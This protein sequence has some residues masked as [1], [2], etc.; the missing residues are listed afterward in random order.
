MLDTHS[1]NLTEAIRSLVRDSRER[2]HPITASAPVGK[3][4]PKRRLR[5]RQVRE[6]RTFYAMFAFGLLLSGLELFIVLH[7]L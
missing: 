3:A 5:N 1:P 7:A 4:Q 6:R 2:R